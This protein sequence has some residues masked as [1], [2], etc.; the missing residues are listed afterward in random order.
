MT[1]NAGS[2][3]CVI[4]AAICLTLSVVFRANEIWYRLRV[5]GDVGRNAVRT[6]AIVSETGRVA[7]VGICACRI[8]FRLQANQG[9][10]GNLRGTPLISS[11]NR[12]GLR[13]PV[14]M[15]EDEE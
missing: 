8:A 11:T 1:L 13:V 3:T 6:D 4:I 14:S 12:H 7:V 9:A 2:S 10:L 5:L 15:Y